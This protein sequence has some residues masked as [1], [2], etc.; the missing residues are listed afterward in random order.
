MDWLNR[1]TLLTAYLR[2]LP[3]VRRELRHWAET[4]AGLPPP[5]R[6]LA[7]AS[8]RKKEFHCL[9]GAVYALYPGAKKPAVL[10]AV[11]ALQTISDYLDNLCDRAHVSDERAFRTLH[12]SLMD[13]VALR[14]PLHDYYADYPWREKAYLPGLV[15]ACRAALQALPYYEHYYE[16]VRLL[17]EWYC[18]LQVLK[19]A[20]QREQ[21]LRQWTVR[22]FPDTLPWQEWAAAS[23]STLGIFF[24]FALSSCPPQLPGQAVLRVYFPW[25]Q[26]LHILLDY[27]IDQSEDR[28]H[29][30]LNFTFFYPTREA[31]AASLARLAL[32][33]R[34][35]AQS[36][37]HAYFHLTVID[38]LVAL[39]GSD[40]KAAQQGQH[41]IF[42]TLSRRSPACVLLPAC[43][44]L[45]GTG[46]IPPS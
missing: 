22:S 11:T 12:L 34:R 36:L 24:C 14:G 7:E 32:E 41:D 1:L 30:D 19:H 15:K 37:P 43:R 33:S 46:A 8:L 25:L 2:L 28:Q 31:L 39:Y 35:R 27:L 13:A 45:R 17:A 40:P 23:G 6:E 10:R 4:A 38:G 3:A 44:A 5:L 9:G 21:L 42:R 29:G 18:E 16:T 26:G 20:P